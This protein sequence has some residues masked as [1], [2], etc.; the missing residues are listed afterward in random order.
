LILGAWNFSGLSR[1]SFAKAEAWMLD[2]WSFASRPVAVRQYLC[3]KIKKSKKAG[4]GCE[5]MGI[6]GC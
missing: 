4:N 1:R 5:T 2:A 6:D 3:G